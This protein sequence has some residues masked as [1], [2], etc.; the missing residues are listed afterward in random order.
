MRYAF[1]AVALL[2]AAIAIFGY[3]AS[4]KLDSIIFGIAAVFWAV[5]YSGTR[6]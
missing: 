3:V 6:T 4:A 5:L 2:C 1:L